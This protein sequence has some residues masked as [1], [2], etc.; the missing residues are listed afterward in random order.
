[1]AP[2][3]W[4]R[5]APYGASGLYGAGM[6]PEPHLWRQ[7]PYNI[8]QLQRVGQPREQ[9]VQLPEA[10]VSILL[11]FLL[12]YTHPRPLWTPLPRVV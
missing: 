8:E 6:A 10:G 3:V 1:M 11:I 7:E 4:R 2:D 12:S 9:G 5:M